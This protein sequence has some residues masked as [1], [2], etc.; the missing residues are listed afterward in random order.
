MF[1]CVVE[2][3][4]G[5]SMQLTG[6]SDYRIKDIEGLDPSSS[7]IIRAGVAGAN[8]TKYKS[9]KVDEKN[10]VMYVSIVQNVESA[11]LTLYKYFR[12]GGYSKLYFTNGQRNVFI[13]GYIEDISINHFGM[14]QTAQISII[15]PQPF[16]NSLDELRVMMSNVI[17]M[18]RF[19]YATSGT[20]QVMSVYQIA[21]E[22]NLFNAGDVNTGLTISF[23]ARGEV[24]NPKIINSYTLEFIGVN[25]IMQEGDEIVIN[26]NRGNRSVTLIRGNVRTNLFNYLM[27]NKTWIELKPGDNIFVIDV[28]QGD[29]L[30]DVVC[31]Y[32]DLFEGV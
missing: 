15:C 13:E 24:V 3:E 6:H 25:F 28:E 27:E 26:T 4:Q 30:L 31:T 12:T 29:S 22:K 21:T 1:R 20:G 14:D 5:D 7:T 32:R 18:L 2:N 10:I 9:S 8:G 23:K 11:R 17:P 16:F 19:P